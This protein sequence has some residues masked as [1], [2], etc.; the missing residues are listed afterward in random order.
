MPIINPPGDGNC[1]YYAVA[2][3]LIDIVK[4]ELEENNNNGQSTTLNN[5]NEKVGKGNYSPD[6]FQKFDLGQVN[7]ENLK[8]LQVKLRALNAQ[9]Y[10]ADYDSKKNESALSLQR[11]QI[12]DE[13]YSLFENKED[14]NAVAVDRLM[15]DKR[16]A[17]AADLQ[18][19][20]NYLGLDIAIEG[21]IKAE[22]NGKPTINLVFQGGN[23]WQTEVKSAPAP[24]KNIY[25]ANK[26][27]ASQ[28]K[29][30]YAEIVNELRDQYMKGKYAAKRPSDSFY[31]DYDMAVQLQDKEFEEAGY[32][33][34][35]K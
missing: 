2:I 9:A 13:G 35:P 31:N 28:D 16:W 18:V 1:G 27:G 14:T 22:N 6:F 20:S 29:I 24:S 30:N 19:L 5:F 3:G 33:R 32:K 8:D 23:H 34:G 12:V 21:K 4:Q 26:T 7:A 25:V 15:I 17:T 11:A 10:L